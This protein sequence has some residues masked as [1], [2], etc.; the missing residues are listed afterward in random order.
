M[1]KHIIKGTERSQVIH[2][3]DGKDSV[4]APSA[5]VPIV[6]LPAVPV[7]VTAQVHGQIPETTTSANIVF[8]NPA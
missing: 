1:S 4:Q 3:D 7:G 2:S 6:K 8:D 5:G